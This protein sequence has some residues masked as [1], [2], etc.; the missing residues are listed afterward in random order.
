MQNNSPLEE[1]I[2]G[3]PVR[4][5]YVT[6]LREIESEGVGGTIP[7][8]QDTLSS[9]LSYH[10][11]GHAL[12]SN[13]NAEHQWQNLARQTYEIAAIIA[14]DDEVSPRM[15]RRI[16]AS[17]LP[18]YQVP[19]ST[20]RSIKGNPQAK[21]QAK[22]EY[23]RRILELTE[24]NKVDVILSDSYTCLFG[25]TVLDAMGGRVL[26]IHPAY[27]QDLPGITPTAD[28]VFRHGIFRRINSSENF[29]WRDGERFYR[30]PLRYEHL[31]RARNMDEVMQEFRARRIVFNPEEISNLES[32]S[33]TQPVGNIKP[34]FLLVRMAGVV[35]TDKKGRQYTLSAKNDHID[36]LEHESGHARELF[37]QRFAN[38]SIEQDEQGNSWLV[39]PVNGE[40][41]R[42]PA[43]TG[44]TFHEI[45]AGID[46]GPIIH[47]ARSTAIRRQD[48]SSIA[49]MKE[50][51]ARQAESHS[52]GVQNLR[53]RNYITKNEVLKIGI[54][55][56]LR[57]E[58][59]HNLVASS[60]NGRGAVARNTASVANFVR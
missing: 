40:R 55:K 44:A 2:N 36:V 53:E 56:H 8:E 59:M 13:G 57:S 9:L 38:I 51:S 58:Q 4:I 20:W 42:F 24:Q 11:N 29:V 17:D 19:S 60:R 31:F 46:T 35:V 27:T 5:A 39:M 30:I 37:V 7:L 23:E 43:K 41:G 45:D 6:S 15:A 14:D 28:A 3:R 21:A 12:G 48:S 32:S 10:S 22:A 25:P 33:K 18:F 47:H 1:T 34:R 26:N 54:L 50:Q 16:A 49:S 52:D